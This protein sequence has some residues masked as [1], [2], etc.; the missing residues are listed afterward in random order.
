MCSSDLP[1]PLSNTASAT[2]AASWEADLFGGDRLALQAAEARTAS[3]QAR[4]HDAR[5]LVAAETAVQYLGYRYC[6]AVRAQLA[7]DVQALDAL[8]RVTQLGAR[9]GLQS[10][11]IADQTDAQRAAARARLLAQRAACDI[12]IKALVALTALQE[13]D[14]RTRLLRHA[15]RSLEVP[16]V[17][18]I[19]SLPTQV[20]AQ[21]PDVFAA[22]REVVAAASEIGV[23]Q[24]SRLPRLTLGGSIGAFNLRGGPLN[25]NLNTWSMGPLQL[26][27]PVF[28]GGDRKSTRLNSSH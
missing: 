1:L 11:S 24:A 7:A 17:F 21:R 14:L 27:L 6:E 28:D 13:E 16:P 26:Q 23:A 12:D 10:Q 18:A 15:G 25:A 3:A 5:V 8:G 20:I 2:L 9:A 22:E 4:W 19:A